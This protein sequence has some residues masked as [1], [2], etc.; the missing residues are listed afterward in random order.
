MILSEDLA[1]Q[2]AQ[3]ERMAE[4]RAGG[5]QVP[6][7]GRQFG[8]SGDAVRDALARLPTLK[9]RLRA[10]AGVNASPRDA[11]GKLRILRLDHGFI[12]WTSEMDHELR[13]L[14][15]EGETDRAIGR[16][17][18]IGENVIHRRRVKLGILGWLDQKRADRAATMGVPV[19]T[20]TDEMDD[21]LRR[22]RDNRA[23]YR[24]ISVRMGV[25][26]DDVMRRCGTIVRRQD[27]VAAR[28][29]MHA[30]VR[31]LWG[32]MPTA[33]IGARIGRGKNAV[34]SIAHRLGLR[35]LAVPG[36]RQVVEPAEVPESDRPVCRA[37]APFPAGSPETWGILTWATGEPVGAYG[38]APPAQ[39][40][41]MMAA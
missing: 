11:D 16:A 8:L 31:E 23:S 1:E 9:A 36:V 21:E 6:D 40:L 38:D 22:L 32:T 26:I 35:L 3:I 13:R 18:G 28:I 25:P 24:T 14:R 33:E 34:I 10:V 41:R 4:L 27:E 30:T 5:M 2:V 37:A 29:A 39:Q 20:W 12:H 15:G 17:W 19:V 7:I